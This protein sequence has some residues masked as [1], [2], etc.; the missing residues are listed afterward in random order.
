MVKSL[1]YHRF[2]AGERPVAVRHVA[3]SQLPRG[4][5]A[6]GRVAARGTWPA[7]LTLLD[8][9]VCPPRDT[10]G[11]SHAGYKRGRV[12]GG[13]G[14]IPSPPRTRRT[15]NPFKTG[16]GTIFRPWDLKIITV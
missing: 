7:L 6:R 10:L 11:T 14:N 9:Y 16:H 15:E 1:I 3:V 5:A 13:L 12:R 8:E 4:R 2:A